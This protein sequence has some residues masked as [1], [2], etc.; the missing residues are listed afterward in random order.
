[1]FRIQIVYQNS[2]LFYNNICYI[3]LFHIYTMFTHWFVPLT[4]FDTVNYRWQYTSPP[5]MELRNG[6]IEK[7]YVHGVLYAIAVFCSSHIR[8]IHCFAIISELPT[9]DN[10]ISHES[11]VCMHIK[12]QEAIQ[13]TQLSLHNSEASVVHSTMRI[14]TVMC[15]LLLDVDS[16]VSLYGMC[17]SLPTGSGWAYATVWIH[18]LCLAIS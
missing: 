4:T 7:R 1:M 14:H 17:S 9:K 11:V 12:Q 18:P 6:H 3:M 2:E 13:I 5:H 8:R 16:L 10:K 15:F